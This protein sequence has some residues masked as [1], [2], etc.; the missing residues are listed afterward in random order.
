MTT[1]TFS[2]LAATTFGIFANAALARRSVAKGI[3]IQGQRDAFFLSLLRVERLFIKNFIVFCEG[4]TTGLVF[5]WS[6]RILCC[7]KLLY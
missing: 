4:P 1:P 7:T 6:E 5:I 3:S 2:W